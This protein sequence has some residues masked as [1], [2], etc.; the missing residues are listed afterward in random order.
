MMTTGAGWLIIHVDRMCV[1]IH[2][3]VC[4]RRNICK[5]FSPVLATTFLEK[6]F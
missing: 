3:Y 6:S 5:M 1:C 2:V 4:A